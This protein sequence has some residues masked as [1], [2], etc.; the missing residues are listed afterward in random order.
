MNTNTLFPVRMFRPIIGFAVSLLLWMSA[1]TA[2]ERTYWSEGHGDII[3]EYLDGQWEWTVVIDSRDGRPLHPHEVVVVLDSNG[4]EVIPEG[5]EFLGEPGHPVWI[6]PQNHLDGVP[7]LSLESDMEPEGEFRDITLL[8]DGVTGP[9]D[10]FWWVTG[11]NGEADLFFNTRDGIDDADRIILAPH[12][13]WHQ[14]WAFDTPGT[15]QLSFIAEGNRVDGGDPAVSDPGTFR[16]AVNVLDRGE[17]DLEVLFE[18]GE[19]ELALLRHDTGEEFE[20]GDVVLHAGP[21][22]MIPVP[23]DSRFGFLGDPG[24]PVYLLSQEEK[25]DVLAFHTAGD[26][27]PAGIFRNDEVTLALVGMEGPGPL[28]LYGTDAFGTPQVHFDTSDGITGADSLPVEVGSHAH[29]S[30]AARQPGYYRFDLGASGVLA[31]DGTTVSSEVVSFLLEVYPPVGLDSGELDLEVGFEDEAWEMVLIDDATGNLHLTEDVLVR[32]GTAAL[33]QVPPDPAFSFLGEPGAPVHVLPQEESEGVPF[34]GFASDELENGVFTGD[35][36]NLQL[37]EHSGPGEVL[38]YSVDSFGA[39]TV[40]FDT[41][42]GIGT[43]DFYP[44]Q[45]GGH[46]HLNLAFTR[47]GFYRL[48]LRPE[49]RLASDNETVTGEIR[50]LLFLMESSTG[51]ALGIRRDSGGAPVLFWDSRPGRVYHV[52]RKAAIDESGWTT[53]SSPLAGTGGVLEHPLDPAGDAQAF[54]RITEQ[55]E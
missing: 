45:A 14:N 28:W 54:F 41:R 33:Q 13:H 51:L 38:L 25:E 26:E 18:D 15:Y 43:E 6:L 19:W 20:P 11:G 46:F 10:F 23:G 32:G 42:D 40:H 50:T 30:L 48:G 49:G 36:V 12:G 16:I 55:P 8:L 35:M 5:Y 47:P 1:M 29:L 37:A 52:Q 22:S 27:I 7:F 17:L 2:D 44:L 39:P 4:Q 21:S 3:F 31:E 53:L 34:L 24:D 9:G